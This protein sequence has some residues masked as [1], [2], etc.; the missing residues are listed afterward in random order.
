ML[1]YICVSSLLFSQVLFRSRVSGCV[2]VMFARFAFVGLICGQL[3]VGKPDG[4]FPSVVVWAE[5]SAADLGLADVVGGAG[6]A[7]GVSE[8]QAA[9]NDVRAFNAALRV[10]QPQVEAAA[11]QVVADALGSSRSSSAAGFLS[12]AARPV[13]TMEVEVGQGAPAV[14]SPVASAVRQMEASWSA[15][16]SRMIG[17]WAGDY[18]ALTDFVLSEL[19]ARPARAV[20]TQGSAEDVSP[21]KVSSSVSGSAGA[22]ASALGAAGQRHDLSESLARSAHLSLQ[23]SFLQRLN[24]YVEEALRSAVAAAAK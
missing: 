8:A 10:A 11:R 19:R 12:V 4:S 7:R 22:V 24:E 3:V 6:A 18:A 13:Y 20:G 15:Q 5:P 23:L 2:P 14:G 16:E 17:G 9:Q 1:R 21:R